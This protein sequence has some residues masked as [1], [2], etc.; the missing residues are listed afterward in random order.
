MIGNVNEENLGGNINDIAAAV[1]A[2]VVETLITKVKKA[3]IKLPVKSIV[4]GGGVAANK[5]LREE[6]RKSFSKPVFFP[7]LNLSMDNGIMVAGAAYFNYKILP[8][9]KLEPEPSILL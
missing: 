5:S 3:T 6:A 1:Q 4:F 8:W 7:P 2:A 9:Y